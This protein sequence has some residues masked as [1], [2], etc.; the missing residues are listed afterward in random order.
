MALGR[1]REAEVD[2]TAALAADPAQAEARLAQGFALEALGRRPEAAAA[3]RAF[4][5][6]APQHPAATRARAELEHLR[7]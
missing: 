6:L 7:R 1:A 4:L 2:L 5:A 3:F